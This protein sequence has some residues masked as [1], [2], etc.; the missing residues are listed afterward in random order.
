[1]KRILVILPIIFLF[2][3]IVFAN[4]TME[5]RM[6]DLFGN[7]KTYKDFF[8]QLKE[9]VSKGD[10]IRVSNLIGYPVAVHGDDI[11]YTIKSKNE[12]L[13]LYDSIFS[14]R[15]LEILKQQKF[16]D[17]FARWSGVM[18]GNGEIWY[19]GI[20]DD[21]ECNKV[22]VEIRNFDNPD[23][24][25]SGLGKKA[26]ED[27]LNSEKSKLHKSLRTFIE[28]VLLWHTKKFIIRVDRI[29]DSKFRYAAWYINSNQ[30]QKP[31]IILKNGIRIFE[32]SGGNHYY[33]FK[34][35]AYEYRCDVTMVGTENS[36]PGSIEVFNNGKSMLYQPVIKVLNL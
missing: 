27:L 9:A 7:H 17:L 12:F 8:F 11:K 22:T 28:P 29:D 21:D 15:L 35:G 16:Q 10:K 24:F 20:C 13:K 6:D 4:E 1:M 34:N 33:Q 32:G 18:I 5:Q 23:F 2:S 14:A 30:S 19:H 3:S 36:P 26:M 25:K 31:N